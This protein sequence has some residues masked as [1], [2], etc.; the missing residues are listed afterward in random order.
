M[1]QGRSRKRTRKRKRFWI[2]LAGTVILLVGL[3]VFFRLLAKN[4]N[5]SFPENGQQRELVEEG[6]DVYSYSFLYL[7]SYQGLEMAWTGN[8]LSFGTEEH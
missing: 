6:E 1:S 4:A 7:P 2:A 8:T 5:L 3:A